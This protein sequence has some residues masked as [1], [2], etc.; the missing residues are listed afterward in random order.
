MREEDFLIGD[1]VLSGDS[2]KDGLK[3]F[4]LSEGSNIYRILPPMFSLA[5]EGKYFKYWRI[6][7][8]FKNSQGRSKVIVCVEEKDFRTKTITQNCPICDLVTERKRQYEQLKLA[9][10]RGDSRVTKDVLQKFWDEKVFPIDA[11]GKYYVNAVNDQGE[12]GVLALGKKTK[13]ALEAL[14]LKLRNEENISIL[15]TNGIYLDIHR[16]GKGR[17]TNYTVSPQMVADKTNPRLKGYREHIL[18]A[19][20]IERLKK[21]ATDLAKLYR[22]ITLEQI[23]SLVA[24][25]GEERAK[26][27]DKIFA[28]PD[29]EEG[30]DTST[31][32]QR[33]SNGA[34]AT[35]TP[36]VDKNGEFGVRTAE[37]PKTVTPSAEQTLRSEQAPVASVSA[38]SKSDG[39]GLDDMN[40]DNL[41]DEE[42]QRMMS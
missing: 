36:Y 5:S 31:G 9:F 14:A 16:S 3:N 22:P 1:A 4:K 40:L 13:D 28:R 30:K 39:L 7:F 37:E 35:M 17:D 32:A 42:F 23:Q 2:R 38:E 41:S 20:M 21:D 15:G 18:D 10:E 19:A 6:H 11:Q 25:E 27:V 34:T 33:L 24:V 8:G 26:L 12:I 29:R